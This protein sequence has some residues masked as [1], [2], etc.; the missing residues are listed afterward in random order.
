PGQVQ[1]QGQ[2]PGQV[3]G[4]GQGQGQGS[5]HATARARVQLLAGAPGLTAPTYDLA[6]LAEVLPARPAQVAQLDL[7]GDDTRQGAA[8][9]WSGWVVPA[10]VAVAALF[11]LALLRRI[12]ADG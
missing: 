2:G 12:L 10:A 1:G 5:D 3:Q 9:W 6:A 4:Q 11:L 8:P 7:S